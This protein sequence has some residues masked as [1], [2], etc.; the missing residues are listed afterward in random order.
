[1]KTK[2]REVFEKY[3]TPE[4]MERI[5]EVATVSRMWEHCLDAYSDNEAISDNGVSYTFA[6]IEARASRLRGLLLKEHDAAKRIGLYMTNSVSFAEA[7]LAIVTAGFT[8]VILPPQLDDKAVFG[9]CMKFD[10]GTLLYLPSMEEKVQTAA[11]MAPGIK[12]FPADVKTL[13][14]AQ[15]QSCDATT[16]CVVMFTG[17]T[18]GQS[19]GALLSNGAVMQGVVNGC[20]GYR[21]VF[22]QRYFLVLPLSH[23]FGLIRNLLTSFYTG[24]S[25]F[26]CK[27]N[28]DMFRDI[29]MF[30]PTVL[31]VVPALAEMALKLS[32]Q[33]GRNMLGPD[34]KYVIC[35][36]AAVAPYLLSEYRKFGISLFPGYGLTESAN[37][38]SGNPETVEKPDAVGILYPNQEYRIEEGELWLRGSNIM[39][40]Y[41]GEPETGMED[42]WFKTGDLVKVDADGFLY[43]VGRKKEVIVL[44]NGENVSPAEVEA[45]FNRLKFVQDSQVFEDV[46]EGGT[47]ILALEIVPRVSE[48]NDVAQEDRNTYM[49]A[50]LEQVNATLPGYQRVNRMEIRETDFERTPSMKIVRY[51]KC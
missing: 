48:L 37:L 50:A 6:Q 23:V 40:G 13:E 7:F 17:G 33:F 14:T 15:I 1:M 21:D 27:N 18:T 49:M 10:I 47:H 34:M 4:T 43:I 22:E 5:R 29:A 35:G 45:K 36:A 39:D 9:C 20:Y 11:K 41:I 32:K 19:K 31:V 12:L 46:T 30:K 2:G 26:I 28:M 51:H 8:A 3:T 42:G 24:S 38:V 16:P 44:A 25:L